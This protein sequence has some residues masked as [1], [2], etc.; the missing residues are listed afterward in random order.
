MITEGEPVF[1]IFVLV[2]FR[3]YVRLIQS[4]GVEAWLWF[5]LWFWQYSVCFWDKGMGLWDGYV[6]SCVF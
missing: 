6:C 1:M 4:C 2:K 5:W 3:Y